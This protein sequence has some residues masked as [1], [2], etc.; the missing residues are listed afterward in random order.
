MRAC[1]V[2][3]MS[4]ACARLIGLADDVVGGG[5][6]KTLIKNGSGVV[7]VV[8]A[9]KLDYCHALEEEHAGLVLL[10]EAEVGLDQL[11]AG[12]RVSAH[13]LMSVL[14]E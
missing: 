7:A 9:R 6:E 3:P 10:A 5:A 2:A 4:D 13:D 11:L 12:R 1:G 14:A 8:N